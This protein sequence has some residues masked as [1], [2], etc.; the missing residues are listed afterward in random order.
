MGA[1]QA[2]AL[3]A[4]STPAISGTIA[5]GH[6]LTLS[7]GTWTGNPTISYGIIWED[8]GATGASCADIAGANVPSFTPTSAQGGHEL[9]AAVVAT[10][11]VGST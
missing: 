10:N 9:R 2:P 3:E 5:V 8:C 4:G 6:A 11:S 7:I 1:A